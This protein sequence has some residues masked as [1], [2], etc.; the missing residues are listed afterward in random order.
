MENKKNE[1]EKKS[2]SSVVIFVPLG[3]LMALLTVIVLWFII[4]TARYEASPLILILGALTY[5]CFSHIKKRTV[6]GIYSA[7]L[8]LDNKKIPWENVRGI[9]WIPYNNGRGIAYILQADLDEA[10][11]RFDWTIIGWTAVVFLAL[12]ILYLREGPIRPYAGSLIPMLYIFPAMFG[13]NIRR[14]GSRSVSVEAV[15]AE[16]VL[17]HIKYCAEQY[18]ISF[19]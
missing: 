10:Q 11:K 14:P 16:S 19:Q 3:L 4:D 5:F 12:M 6:I 15:D 2:S 13:V 1:F 9:S 17:Q 7:H 18:H 8:T